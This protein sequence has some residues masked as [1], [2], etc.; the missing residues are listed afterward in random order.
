MSL[1]S[2]IYIHYH[3]PLCVKIEHIGCVKL[4]LC[5]YRG[6]VHCIVHLMCDT[7][8]IKDVT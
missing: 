2:C 5:D 4:G 6:N 8:T 7:I 1:I 3:R